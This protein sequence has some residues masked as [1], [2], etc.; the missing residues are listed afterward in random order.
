MQATGAVQRV[1]TFS[2]GEY[3]VGRLRPGEYEVRVAAS[4]LQAL[5]ARAEP[6]AVRFT[7]SSSGDEILVEAPPIQVLKTGS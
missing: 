2:D 3:Y 7:V 4:S 5:G 1:P 6:E